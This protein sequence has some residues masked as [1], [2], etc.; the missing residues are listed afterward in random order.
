MTWP[1]WEPIRGPAFGLALTR[2]DEFVPET[3]ENAATVVF[4]D[5]DVSRL[6][7]ADVVS[8]EAHYFPPLWRRFI[9]P[10]PKGRPVIRVF[11][12]AKAVLELRV[13]LPHAKCELPGFLGIEIYTQYSI[14]LLADAGEPEDAEHVHESEPGFIFSGSTGNLR[15]NEDGELL[16]DG[17]YCMYPVHQIAGA[18]NLDFVPDYTMKEVDLRRQGGPIADKPAGPIDPTGSGTI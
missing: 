16:G 7:D 11:H 14:S 3:T 15:R 9:R 10:D 18:R 1:L 4:E 5:T 2:L 17:I 6:D 13:L 8:L 12:P